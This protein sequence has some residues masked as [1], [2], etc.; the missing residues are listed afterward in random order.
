MSYVHRIN[1]TPLSPIP[2]DT[3]RT[4]GPVKLMLGRAPDRKLSVGLLIEAPA[5]IGS[6]EVSLTGPQVQD[7]AHQLHSLVT[8]NAA[9]TAALIERLHDRGDL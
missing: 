9:E 3:I 8:L 7:L 6:I 1:T 2:D 5:P 4:C